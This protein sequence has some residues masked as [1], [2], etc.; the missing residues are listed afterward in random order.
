MGCHL[1]PHA[2]KEKEPSPTSSAPTWR[3]VGLS[4]YIS[5]II[6]LRIIGVTLI[7]P[8]RGNI[9]RVISPVISSY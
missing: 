1:L 5:G 8:S 2:R 6:T 9:G 3:P 4:N 7:S